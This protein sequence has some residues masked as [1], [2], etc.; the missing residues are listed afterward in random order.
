MNFS[1]QLAQHLQQVFF[2]GN[3]T[4][5]NVKEQLSDVSL[6]DAGTKLQSFNTIAALAY[7]IGYYVSAISGVL[8]GKP[9]DS[10]DAYSFEHPPFNKEESW[11]QFLEQTWAEAA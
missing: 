1:Y 7:H 4:T 8:Q 5:V 6:A 11:Q 2:G 3:W 10:K 9:L